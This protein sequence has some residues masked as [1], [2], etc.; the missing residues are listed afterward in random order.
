MNPPSPVPGCQPQAPYPVSTSS[1]R[2]PASLPAQA[3]PVVRTAIPEASDMWLP[4]E[5][6]ARVMDVLPLEN[7]PAAALVCKAWYQAAEAARSA[8]LL[9]RCF[10]DLS[11]PGAAQSALF[12]QYMVQVDAFPPRHRLEGLISLARL[13]RGMAP[14]EQEQ[15]F[16]NLMA[17]A[18]RLCPEDRCALLCVL[19]IRLAPAADGKQAAW[20]PGALGMLIGAA[21]A[22]PVQAQGMI[23]AALCC[24]RQNLE[25]A[26]DSFLAQIAGLVASWMLDELKKPGCL[27]ARAIRLCVGSGP[28]TART[29]SL[30]E[31]FGYYRLPSM[32]TVFGGE[33]T[34]ARIAELGREI[35]ALDLEMP[36]KLKILAHHDCWNFPWLARGWMEEAESTGL[37]YVKAMQALPLPQDAM[38]SLLSA[39]LTNGA[40]LLS[41]F[42]RN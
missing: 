34:S 30:L 2:A 3:P 18:S 38:V 25:G 23:V 36:D 24:N 9:L 6:M 26:S 31:H 28:I 41:I 22:L 42:L 37:A 32:T 21:R 40:A 14:E 7:V 35:L 8:T 19:A 5:V 15:A 17:A 13:Q 20:L 11:V 10:E 1:S 16:R 4:T 33:K 39:G 12:A 29:R 27:F